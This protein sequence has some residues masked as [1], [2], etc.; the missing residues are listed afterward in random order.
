MS[1]P[2]PQGGVVDPRSPN[3]KYRWWEGEKG[4]VHGALFNLVGSMYEAADMRR[5]S[6]IHFVRLYSN[7]MAAAL[8]GQN[9]LDTLDSGGKIRLNVTRSAL[10]AAV[11]Q[12]ATNRPRPLYVTEDGDVKLRRKA[13][14][15]GKFAMGWFNLLKLYII[16]LDIF[17]DAGIWGTGFLHFYASAGKICCE[18]VLQDEIFVDE[19][20]SRIGKPF[21]LF[22]RM[23]ASRQAL[24][25]R[26]P[27]DAEDIDRS[28]WLDPEA[29]SVSRAVPGLPDPCT[30][31][32]VWKLP[33]IPGETHD[34]RHCICVSNKTLLDE[35]WNHS[36]FPFAVFRWQPALLGYLG[37]G[38]VEELAPMQV[39]VNY[40]M[41]KIQQ[42]MTLATSM[43]WVE[44][45]SNVGQINND[46]FALREYTGRPPVF[47][48]TQSVSA[49]YFAHVD[50]IVNYCYQLAG[51]SQMAAGSL[52]PAGLE[53]GE[54]LRVYNDIGTRRFQH[55]GQRWEQ[56]YLD[57][58]E[59]IMRCASEI[60]EKGEGGK[61]ILAMG[62]RDVMS[63]S[64]KDIEMKEDAY[65]LKVHPVSIIPDT[66]AGKIDMLMKLGQLAPTMAPYF[67]SMVSGIPDLE[68]AVSLMNSPVETAEMYIDNILENGEY[69]KP[70]PFLNLPL[71]R[72][73]AQRS[74]LKAQLQG[75]NKDRLGMLTSF[76]EDID[77]MQDQAQQAVAQQAQAQAMQMQGAQGGAGMTEAA[78]GAQAGLPPELLGAMAGVPTGGP[79]Q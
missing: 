57:C 7:R 73:I 70:S 69:Q 68:R 67:I 37:A 78:Q 43:T 13:K 45:G 15:R 39:E 6:S 34:G 36:D 53:S 19:A 4:N 31:V 56:F 60:E 71:T 12:I 41:Q 27:K 8:T 58:A 50:R 66:P 32:E 28:Q 14:N 25:E 48:T 40:L 72:D 20:E 51:I 33:S 42:L 35:E 76:I 61:R 24:K 21:N 62:D 44:K 23:N 9:Y 75:V 55:T 59:Q 30:A 29:V 54:A 47:Q 17:R 10:D 5:A 74:L 22:R 38:L 2:F 63:L 77:E 26:F 79:Q 18:R 46:N 3:Q 52:K 64:F 49:E 11:A 1:Y 65:V 16:G